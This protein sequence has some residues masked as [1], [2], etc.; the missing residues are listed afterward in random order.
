MKVAN[1]HRRLDLSSRAILS[2]R[3]SV[4]SYTQKPLGRPVEIT[5]VESGP[6]L[7]KYVREIEEVKVI[8]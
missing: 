8:R 7:W 2:S 5:L 3:T 4:E 6:P 1:H